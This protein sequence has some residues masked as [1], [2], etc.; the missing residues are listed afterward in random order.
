MGFVG[1]RDLGIKMN[2]DNVVKV[3]IPIPVELYKRICQIGKARK[4]Q[5]NRATASPLY[6]SIEQDHFV[7]AAEGCGDRIAIWIPGNADSVLLEDIPEYLRVYGP[8]D[9]E[10][11]DDLGQ[12]LNGMDSYELEEYLTDKLGEACTVYEERNDPTRS[13]AFITAE[14][15]DKHIKQNAHHYLNGR[16]YAEHAFRNPEM[17]AVLDIIDAITETDNHE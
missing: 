15:C 7:L 14:A 4:T 6:F 3:L 8:D 16:S 17:Q 9:T 5:S 1:P 11:P 2:E 12:Q 10:W 13:N